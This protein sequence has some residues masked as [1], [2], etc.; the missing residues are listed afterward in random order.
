MSITTQ[1]VMLRRQLDIDHTALIKKKNTDAR[2]TNVRQKQERAEM[3]ARHS[4]EDFDIQQGFREAV[5][6]MYKKYQVDLLALT[7]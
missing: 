4:G 6:A 5:E 3:L 7:P 1:K 2:E